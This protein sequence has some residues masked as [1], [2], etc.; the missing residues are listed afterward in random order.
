MRV[1]GIDPASKCGWAVVEDADASRVASGVWRGASGGGERLASFWS[2]LQ[3]LLD[4]YRPDVICYELPIIYKGRSPNLTS[5]E[6]GALIQVAAELRGMPYAGADNA[7]VKVLAGGGGSDK[8]AIIAA[9]RAFFPEAVIAT[10]DEAD[11][12][13]LALYGAQELEW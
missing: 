12:L 11:A 1:L 2:W 5:I 8:A 9:A 4:H 10:D 3:C 6:M 13:L 7:S